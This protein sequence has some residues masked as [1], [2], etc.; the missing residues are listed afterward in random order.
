MNT[1][2]MSVVRRTPGI[3]VCL[4]L[5]FLIPCHTLGAEVL[6]DQGESGIDTTSPATKLRQGASPSVKT[7]Y[8]LLRKEGE[9]YGF[10]SLTRIQRE[11]NI[12]QNHLESVILFSC[13][14]D[15]PD[16]HYIANELYS[17]IEDRPLTYEVMVNYGNRSKNLVCSFPKEGEAHVSG[18]SREAKRK[19][20][21]HIP[22]KF[23]IFDNNLFG[24][25]EL[26]FDRLPTRIGDFSIP[27]F[28]PQIANMRRFTAQFAG[29]RN[30]S[31]M[32]KRERAALYFCRLAPLIFK[33]WVA[34]D[35]RLLRV[36]IPFM[37]V[38]VERVDRDF[39]RAFQTC[40][41]PGINRGAAHATLLF[42][43]RFESATVA[44]KLSA[45]SIS[46]PKRLLNRPGQ[47]FSGNVSHTSLEGIFQLTSVSGTGDTTH[48]ANT[49][50]SVGTEVA[51]PVHL[52]AQPGIESDSPEIIDTAGA[53]ISEDEN[54]DHRASSITRWVSDNIQWEQGPEQALRTLHR[55]RGPSRGFA[56][57]TVAL[58]RAAGIPARLSHGLA[59]FPNETG[60]FCWHTWVEYFSSDSRW[61]A[62]DP[63]FDEFGGVD[64]LH[65]TIPPVEDLQG[66][67]AEILNL[68][69]HPVGDDPR[70][71]P[72]RAFTPPPSE[73]T[74]YAM[75]VGDVMY[76]YLH[77]ELTE[78]TETALPPGATQ[79]LSH[80]FVDSKELGY[81]NMVQKNNSIILDANGTILAYRSAGRY[82]SKMGVLDDFFDCRIRSG[83][84]EH[85]NYTRPEDKSKKIESI[86][87][88]VPV[89]KQIPCFGAPFIY[90]EDMVDQWT[91][92]FR[93]TDLSKLTW[94]EIPIYIPEIKKVLVFDIFGKDQETIEDTECKIVEIPLIDLKL[95]VS[96]EGSVLRA[97]IKSQRAIITKAGPEVLEIKAD[98]SSLGPIP[99]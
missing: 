99:E 54:S 91:L 14:G 90:G 74:Y 5:I 7:S 21:L 81:D 3:T 58:L 93:K 22:K 71:I 86:D 41:V 89:T 11:E 97:E 83:F 44:V 78:D 55:R 15:D 48:K 29:E 46:F 47:M 92:L 37:D 77:S 75:K 31:I 65:I 66:I 60:F 30:I 72:Q 33:V 16:S 26:I 80:I 94:A 43:V 73:S 82:I 50:A 59:Y 39:V 4:F 69:P 8:F 51:L 9:V 95:W 36:E 67:T 79:Y 85:V 12:V 17:S 49:A 84:V 57:L 70:P 28:V 23:I 68:T 13:L 96:F 45:A 1:L 6:K 53:I 76:G 18:Q 64:R 24:Q 2:H 10:S 27:V 52:A 87:D 25:F 88:L 38:L 42:P 56:N 61:H 35:G 34:A 40:N 19:K 98:E 62:C 20:V 63:F 32:G